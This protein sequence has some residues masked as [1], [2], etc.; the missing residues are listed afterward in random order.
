MET[1]TETTKP[2]KR[3]KNKDRAPRTFH[4]RMPCRLTDVELVE[5]GAS[6][7]EAFA[8]AETLEADRK[9]ANDGFKARI[10][11]A[12]GKVRDLSNVLRTKQETR[13]VELIE[14]YIFATNT[15]RVKRGDTKEVVRE[16]AMTQ[17]E[18]QETLPLED[19]EKE[20]EAPKAKA[21]AAEGEA[22]E[23]TDPAAVLG[24]EGEKTPKSKGRKKKS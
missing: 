1:T 17:D 9:N 16:R 14:E 6:L 22:A 11:I 8:E 20:K 13:E 3:K 23:I 21:A 4:E 10:E 5:R 24:P 18:R 12:E 7:A 15:V 19:S 2:T